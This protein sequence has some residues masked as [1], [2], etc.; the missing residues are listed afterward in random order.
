MI[1]KTNEPKKSLD[2]LE[3]LLK[4]LQNIVLHPT[5]DKFR[6]IKGTNPKISATLFA[7]NGTNQLLQRMSFTEIEPSI[8]VYLEDNLH[9]IAKFVHMVENALNP[10]RMQ[11][12][13][14]DEKAKFKLILQRK[15]EMHEKARLE[16]EHTERLKKQAEYDR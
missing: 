14:E 11:F 8:F 10:I 6:Q 9:Q 7:I 3:I 16:R 5:E 4:L 15:E 13:S 2:G 1:V 12:M